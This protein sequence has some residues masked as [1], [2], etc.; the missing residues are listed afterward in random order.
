MD[1]WPAGVF[2]AVLASLCFPR[3]GK[4]T[5][6]LINVVP[7]HLTAVSD[8]NKKDLFILH[9]FYI[10]ISFLEKTSIR[11]KLYLSSTS[12]NSQNTPRVP[13]R[14]LRAPQTTTFPHHHQVLH[15]FLSLSQY[16]LCLPK[17]SFWR[18]FILLT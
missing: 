11:K 14:M 15:I 17:S 12:S 18:R 8:L 10:F 2:L 7:L 16:S 6:L 4:H 5:L 9:S 13:L 3:F 1:T